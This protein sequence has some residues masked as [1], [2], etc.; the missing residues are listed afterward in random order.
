MIEKNHS[1]ISIKKQC[2]LLDISRSG[3]YYKPVSI[4]KENLQLMRKID[5]IYTESPE[6]GSRL[7]RDTL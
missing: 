4:S 3:Y 2:K 5:E 6:Y 7:I 1:E